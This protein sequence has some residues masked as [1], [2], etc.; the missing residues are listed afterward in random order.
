MRKNLRAKK[1]CVFIS[2]IP[3][4]ANFQTNTM[5]EHNPDIQYCYNFLKGT[6]CTKNLVK[7]HDPGVSA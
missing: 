1:F 4:Q 6:Y 7:G 2:N 3:K 5:R